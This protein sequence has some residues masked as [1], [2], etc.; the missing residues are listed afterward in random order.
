[1]SSLL[2]GAEAGFESIRL[3]TLDV[4]FKIGTKDLRT[5]CFHLT[6]V[7]IM[8]HK[9]I[10]NVGRRGDCWMQLKP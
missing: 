1:M 8:L 6:L 4:S 10:N 3:S 7:H 2:L 5:I 9:F